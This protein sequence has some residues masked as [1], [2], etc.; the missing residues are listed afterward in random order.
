MIR[1]LTRCVN[2]KIVPVVTSLQYS[3]LN[4]VPSF[5]TFHHISITLAKK[6]VSKEQES[7]IIQQNNELKL[8]DTLEKYVMKLLERKN[9]L[10]RALYSQSSGS[11]KQILSTELKFLTQIADKWNEYMALKSSRLELIS[12]INDPKED[13]EMKQLARDELKALDDK[14]E[15]IHREHEVVMTLINDELSKYNADADKDVI[16]EVRPGTGGDEAAIWAM[17]LFSMYEKYSSLKG[18][19]FEVLALQ[20]TSSNG[21]KEGVATVSGQDAYCKLRY[22]SGVHRVQRVPATESQGRIHTSTCSVVVLAQREEVEIKI[23]PQDL[24]IDTYRS[25]GAGGQHVNVTDSAVRI[26]HLPT[27]LQ[28]A[29]SDQRSQTQNKEKAMAILRSRLY[30]IEK[31][32]KEKESLSL[33]SEQIGSG[34]RSDKIRTYN[35]PQ[36]RVTDH[37]IGLSQHDLDS[38]LE[39]ETLDEFIDAMAERE[40]INAYNRIIARENEV[41]S[42]I[43]NKK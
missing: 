9:E 33:R 42:D 6:T 38:V 5:R 28:V 24:R 31:K 1:T 2:I 39:G 15:L 13:E 4:F 26:T 10:N 12:T 14:G 40:M 22:E 11:S 30:E 37:R 32:N 29:I 27:G 7:E 36:Y 41:P 25:S 19:R 16:I 23:N 43:K 18:W 8:N 3:P 17:E 20:K 35:F 21:L 34:D